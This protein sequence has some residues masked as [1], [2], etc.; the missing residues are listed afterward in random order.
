MKDSPSV[1]VIIPVYKTEEYIEKCADSLFKQ[2]LDNIE[3]I[4]IDDN[5]PDRSIDLLTNV[6]ECFPKRKGQV[7][8]IR[9]T[10]NTGVSYV[11]NEG[12][13]IANGEYIIYCDSD[14]YV[15]IEMYEKLYSKAKENNADIVGCDFIIEFPDKT[16]LSKQMLDNDSI[17]CIN[18]IFQEKLH[19]GT[20]NKLIRRKLIIDN[21]IEFPAGIN[22]WE[23][24]ATV[25]RIF[26]YAKKIV[27]VDEALYHYIQFN[28]NSYTK[29][30]N[31]E[32]INKK[33]EVIKILQRF[34]ENN[35][36]LS[37]SLGYLKLSVKLS[38][39]LHCNTQE[40]SGI[41]I[42]ADK[43]IWKHPTISRYNKLLLFMTSNKF[44]C[45]S[46]FLKQFKNFIKR[47]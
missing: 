6:L 1:S 19:A 40:Y 7:R 42:D 23:D 25:P 31:I 39:I 4:F 41:Y 36:I 5:S 32:S 33:K 2:T 9:H 3:Y 21:N 38:L 22:L 29:A 11:R 24:M 37:N 13:Y 18:N 34:F 43:F 20:C 16:V 17:I 35:P 8:I 14:D 10:A 12:L 47:H 46:N 44:Y 26:Y 27:Y 28:V 15:D 45:I 30:F